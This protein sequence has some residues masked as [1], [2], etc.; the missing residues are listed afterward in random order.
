MNALLSVKGL[1]VNYGA[2]RAL[3]GVTLDVQPGETVA[4]IGANGAGKSTLMRTLSGLLRPVSGSAD[5]GGMNLAKTAPH[6]IAQGGLLHI[7][8]GRGTLGRL[9][10]SE[11]LRIAYDRDPAAAAGESFESACERVFLRFPRLKERLKQAAGSMSGGEQQQ[12]AMAR[13]LLAKPK[14]LMLDEPSLGLSPVMVSTVFS[15]LRELR[16]AG[17]TILIVEQ[18][19]RAAL[20]LSQ[21]AY[22]LKQGRMVHEGASAALLADNSVLSHYLGA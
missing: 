13:A 21:R 18:N 5:F 12:L 10:V 1:E 17:M 3:R 22:V 6:L 2:I 4:V 19:A 8:E 14:L 11:N 9:S 20:K 15:V 7:P 16:D